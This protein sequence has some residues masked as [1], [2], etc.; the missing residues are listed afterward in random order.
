MIGE[1][2]AKGGCTVERGNYCVVGH[3]F[4]EGKNFCVGRSSKQCFVHMS[5]KQS[6]VLISVSRE[7]YSHL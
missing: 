4:Y 1:L 7:Q 3:R 6:F 5:C 2:R